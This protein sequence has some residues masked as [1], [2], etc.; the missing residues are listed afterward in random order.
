MSSQQPL[1][2]VGHLVTRL[3]SCG[4]SLQGKDY[5]KSA[6]TPSDDHTILSILKTANVIAVV[7]LSDKPDRPSH[8][9][10]RYLQARGYSIIPVNPRIQEALGVPAV[11][12]LSQIPCQIDIVNIFRQSHEV[13]AVVEEAIA[14]G[15]KAV[16]MQLGVVNELACKRAL[17]AG[18]A[19]IQDRC[20]LVE[21]QRL[22]GNG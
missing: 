12:S 21:H 1:D 13:P 22:I 20:I 10:G 18:M 17:D 15:A 5:M 2:G 11:A 19:V 8:G 3:P 16:W 4:R 7:G 14:H 6:Y 9:V